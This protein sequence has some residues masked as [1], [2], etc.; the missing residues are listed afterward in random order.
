MVTEAQI[1]DIDRALSKKFKSGYKGTGKEPLYQEIPRTPLECVSLNNILGGGI[2]QGRIIEVFGQPSHGKTTIAF[3]IIENF[4]KQH[5]DKIVMFID[6]E[7]TFNGIYASQCGV[8]LDKLCLMGPDTAQEALDSIRTAISL[9]AEEEQEEGEKES[10]SKKV[11]ESAFSLIVLDSVAHMVPSDEYSKDIGGGQIGSLARLMSSS[12]KQISSLAAKHNTTIIFLNQ[13]RACNITGYGPKT[14]TPGGIALHFTC[15]VRL[16]VTKTGYIED[17]GD[18]VGLT[19]KVQA[20]KNK[21]ATPL[22]QAHLELIFPT[23]VNGKTVAGID[24]QADVI[25]L[26]I[27]KG[28]V[29]K[30]GAWFSYGQEKHQGLVNFKSALNE[31]PDLYNDIYSQLVEGD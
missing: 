7:H 19:I 23:E 16:D 4:Q 9:T 21:T 22:K 15:S 20:V 6:A 10:K 2:P 31:N 3:N 18:K 8:D 29:K 26:A 17:K 27:E 25:N 24:V 12:L 28:I 5:P 13:E 11:P 1:Q 30:G 14:T